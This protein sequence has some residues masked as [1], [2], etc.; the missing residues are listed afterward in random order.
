MVRSSD[1]AGAIRPAVCFLALRTIMK[2]SKSPMSHELRYAKSDL[3]CPVCKKS[4]LLTVW[5]GG[6]PIAYHCL[7]TVGCKS[8]FKA[9]HRIGDGPGGGLMLIEC[10]IPIPRNSE[11]YDLALIE[12]PEEG[13]RAKRPKKKK[14]DKK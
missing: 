7:D 11:E 8:R 1:S 6:E 9:T 10:A 13:K 4:K 3:D 12:I 5:R 2:R 14:K